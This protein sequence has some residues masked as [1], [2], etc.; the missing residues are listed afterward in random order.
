MIHYLGCLAVELLL[1]SF[2]YISAYI[3]GRVIVFLSNPIKRPGTEN[4]KTWWSDNKW[5]FSFNIHRLLQL[6]A[7]FF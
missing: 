5:K 4:E 3:I 1:E 7:Y 6:G 2:A